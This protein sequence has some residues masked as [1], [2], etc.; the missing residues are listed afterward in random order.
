MTQSANIQSA[1]ANATRNAGIQTQIACPCRHQPQI[2]HISSNMTMLRCR[3]HQQY[4]GHVQSPS[5]DQDRRASTHQLA[6]RFLTHRLSLDNHHQFL[7]TMAIRKLHTDNLTRYTDQ[8]LRISPQCIRRHQQ[9]QQYSPHR[10]PLSQAH[11]LDSQDIRRPSTPPALATQ[12]FPDWPIRSRCRR[13]PQLTMS[14][15]AP[16][17]VASVALYHQLLLT[18]D[19]VA[20]MITHHRNPRALMMT[21]MK[22]SVGT[23]NIGP[24]MQSASAMSLHDRNHGGANLMSLLKTHAGRPQRSTTR[25][26]NYQREGEA[27]GHHHPDQIWRT[28]QDQTQMIITCHHPSIM[29]QARPPKLP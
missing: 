5:V 10:L 17:L 19:G 11:T 15:W 13:Q 20:V 12:P 28:G 6:Y 25:H 27:T 2:I 22:T 16:R 24:A 7:H 23:S 29:I 9:R 1:R 4:L 21:A 18:T 26:L 14:R 3:R 8:P